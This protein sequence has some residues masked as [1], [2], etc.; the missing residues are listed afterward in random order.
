MSASQRKAQG[1]SSVTRIEEFLQRASN[2]D[3]EPFVIRL[4]EHLGISKATLHVRA[5]ES[6]EFRAA[7]GA[8]KVIRAERYAALRKGIGG[9]KPT[10]TPEVLEQIREFVRSAQTGQV[11]PQIQCLAEHLGITVSTVNRWVSESEEVRSA[12]G[13]LKKVPNSAW[14]RR[15]AAHAAAVTSSPRLPHR[16]VIPESEVLPATAEVLWTAEMPPC[17]IIIDP[18]ERRVTSPYVIKKKRLRKTFVFPV[19]TETRNAIAAIREVTSETRATTLTGWI[20]SIERLVQFMVDESWSTLAPDCFLAFLHHLRVSHLGEGTENHI[21]SDVLRYASWLHED[22]Q[23]SDDELRSMQKAKERQFKGMHKRM[24]ARRF[25]EDSVRPEELIRLYRAI[26]LL[27]NEVAELLERGDE[28][29]V[30]AY[31]PR[32]PLLPFP[33]LLGIEYAMRSKEYIHFELA[34][35]GSEIIVVKAPDKAGRRFLFD[36]HAPELREAWRLA[37]TWQE[38][39]RD[40]W[41][42]HDHPLYTVSERPDYAGALIPF[43]GTPF[44]SALR[45]FYKKFFETQHVDGGPVLFKTVRADDGTE[46]QVPFDLP[47]HKYRHTSAT[48]FARIEPDPMKLAKFMGHVNLSTAESYYIRHRWLEWQEKVA[49]GLQIRSERMNMLYRAIQMSPEERQR[50]KEMNA[51]V[52]ASTAD[53]QVFVIGAC[54]ESLEKGVLTCPTKLQDCRLCP[55]VRID[56]ELRD[57]YVEMAE[58]DLAHAEACSLDG[59]HRNAE[60]AESMAAVSIALIERIDEWRARRVA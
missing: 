58:A 4:A 17:R 33:L 55:F 14:A 23:I 26:R 12:I 21:A 43:E 29:E 56:P 37:R 30:V 28:T 3:V 27:M 54:G 15:E 20:S 25:D 10:R 13:D 40:T 24:S 6:K 39:Y 5:K 41:E 7:I 52:A 18:V 53:G 49:E 1:A 36:Q 16:I 2:G 22:G 48:H 31:P 46:K 34:Q 11:T 57:V 44:T 35:I 45:F 51:E 50:A 42:P 47:W 9:R 59:N 19:H 8:L 32:L 38:R 60:V